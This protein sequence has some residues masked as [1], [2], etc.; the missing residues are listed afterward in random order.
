MYTMQF[1]R[2]TGSDYSTTSEFGIFIDPSTGE[3]FVPPDELRP[4]NGDVTHKLT[5]NLNYLFPEDFKSGTIY[6]KIL[7]NFKIFTLVTLNSGEPAY[8]RIV[9]GGSTYQLNAEEDVSWLTRRGGRPIGGLNY[10]R[11]RW[12]YNVDLRLNK[13]FRL[14]R[15]MQLAFFGEVFN[16]FNKKLPTPYPS[17]YAYEGYFRVPNG[18]VPLEWSDNLTADKKALFNH[19]YDQNGI[20]SLEEQAKGRIA[21]DQMVGTMDKMAYG[22]ARQVR[23]GVE[24]I[25]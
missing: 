10:F 7:G 20:V 17:G 4:I 21:Y 25:F 24:Y 12:D 11:G 6:N 3:Q 16:V 22:V 9:N 15:T 19:D 8:D 18:G 23:M 5:A 2:T 14:G 13:N 1:S